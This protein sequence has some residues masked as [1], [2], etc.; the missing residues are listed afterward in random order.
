LGYPEA[1]TMVTSV[2]HREVSRLIA[3]G[4]LLL[5]VLPREEYEFVHLQGARWLHLRDITAEAVAGFDKER[6]VI[7]YCA[8]SL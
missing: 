1:Y 3:D 5:D 2:G 6:P 8:D 4:T 7:V